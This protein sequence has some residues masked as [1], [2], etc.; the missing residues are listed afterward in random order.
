MWDGCSPRKDFEE[1]EAKRDVAAAYA[2]ATAG[3][4]AFCGYTGVDLSKYALDEP[5]TFDEASPAAANIQGIFPMFKNI[6]RADNMPWTPRRIGEYYCF[7]GLGIMPCGTP[8]LF[9][10]ILEEWLVG[11]DIDGF[12]LFCECQRT[13][14][15]QCAFNPTYL[16]GISKP[17]SYKDAVELLILELQL[18][19]VYWTDCPA[20]EGTFRENLQCTPGEPLIRA[21]HPAANFK[22]NAPKSVKGH[23]ELLSGSNGENLVAAGVDKLHLNPTV[24]IKSTA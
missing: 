20:P 19:G 6:E 4:A 16:A 11:G 18:C 23:E 10:D 12:N 15:T 3:L 24:N 8:A 22:W 13:L 1:A 9:A 14:M 2:S 17:Q 7:G 21:D 5:F